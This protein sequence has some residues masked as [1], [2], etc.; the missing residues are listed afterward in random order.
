M[1][2]AWAEKTHKSIDAL[3]EGILKEYLDKIKDGN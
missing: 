2:R 1:L 3:V